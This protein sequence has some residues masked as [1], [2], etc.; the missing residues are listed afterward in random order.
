MFRYAAIASA[1]LCLVLAA[2]GDPGSPQHVGH[3]GDDNDQA[4]APQESAD[5]GSQVTAEPDA[6][7]AETAVAK[8]P[9]DLTYSADEVDVRDISED[10]LSRYQVDN[11]F[12]EKKGSDKKLSVKPKI[13]LKEDAT[14][15]QTMNN[16][17]DSLD[18]AEMGVEYKTR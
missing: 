5:T 9:L 7:G 16:Y 12:E 11:W 18:G 6:G 1:G 8:P 4:V 10:E 14:L 15:D 3:N 13:R 2:C 17:R